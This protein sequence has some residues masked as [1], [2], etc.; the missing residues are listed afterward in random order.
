M[1]HVQEGWRVGSIIYF[2]IARW[3]TLFGAIFLAGLVFLGLCLVAFWICVLV[4]VLLA[5]LGVPW[6]GRWCLFVF[7]G[8]FGG[9]KTIGVLRTWKAL[10]KRF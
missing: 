4:G 9:R 1:L 8:L 2:F 5:G 7:F 3:P 6:F 10:W